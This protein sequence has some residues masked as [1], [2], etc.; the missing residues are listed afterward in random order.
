MRVI[1]L[2]IVLL[3]GLIHLLGFVKAFGFNEVKELTLPISKQIGMVWLIAMELFLIYGLLYFVNNKYNWV[4]GL[5]SV[6]VSQILIIYFWKDAK[7]GTLPNLII[8]I[9]ILFSYGHSMFVALIEKEKNEIFLKSEN[10]KNEIFAETEIE[11]LPKP[12]K[13]WLINCGA[14]GKAKILN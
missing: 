11:D 13:K 1:F 14:I 4:V 5:F 3:H 2:I 12:V 8:L 6:I 10:K 7:F 9:A